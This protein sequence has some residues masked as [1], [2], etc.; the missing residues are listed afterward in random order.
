MKLLVYLIKLLPP[1]HLRSAI[2]MRYSYSTPLLLAYQISKTRTE[3][4]QAKRN[5]QIVADK[6]LHTPEFINYSLSYFP[7]ELHG[8]AK[9]V[10]E[11]SI[12]I[13]LL[14]DKKV[15]LDKLTEQETAHLKPR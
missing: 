5:A 10:A 4:Q 7:K 11:K 15:K 6:V 3:Y 8:T 1:S 14:L 9:V 2:F 12:L 13:A